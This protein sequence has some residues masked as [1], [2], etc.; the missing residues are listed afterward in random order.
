[1]MARERVNG[2]LAVPS[3]LLRSQRAVLVELSLKHRL[4]GMFGPKDNVEAGGLMSYFAEAATPRMP[5]VDSARARPQ[6]FRQMQRT[7]PIP[8][9]RQA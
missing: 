9:G 1:M 6:H 4:A 2:F 3:P 7:S 5:E 8:A